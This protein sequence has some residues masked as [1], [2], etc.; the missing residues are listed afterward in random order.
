[1]TAAQTT[2]GNEIDLVPSNFYGSVIGVEPD[3]AQG[4][5]TDAFGN[6]ISVAVVSL[7]LT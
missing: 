4:S 3:R 2:A 1:M 7:N 6:S 5:Y